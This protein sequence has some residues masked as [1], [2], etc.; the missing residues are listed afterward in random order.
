MIPNQLNA[1]TEADRQALISNGVAEGRT[2]EYNCELPG[3]GDSDKKEFLGERVP[4]FSRPRSLK[5]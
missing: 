2:L 1:V 5:R 3:N 4:A